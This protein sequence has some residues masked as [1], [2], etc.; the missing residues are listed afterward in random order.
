MKYLNADMMLWAKKHHKKK[1]I[2]IKNET[3]TQNITV[4]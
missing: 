1:Q 2:E 3:D 4:Q